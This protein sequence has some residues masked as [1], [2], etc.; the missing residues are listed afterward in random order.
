MIWVSC[1]THSGR[2]AHEGSDQR[3]CGLSILRGRLS[4]REL[5]DIEILLD[6]RTSNEIS[7]NGGFF[8]DRYSSSA[9]LCHS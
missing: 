5:S 9:G 7:P 8:I 3:F 2:T 1:L 6:Q 4:K